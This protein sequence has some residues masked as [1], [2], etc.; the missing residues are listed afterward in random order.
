MRQCTKLAVVFYSSDSG[1]K[2]KVQERFLMRKGSM[3]TKHQILLSQHDLVHVIKGY[4]QQLLNWF[5]SL[6]FTRVIRIIRIIRNI[7]LK[8]Y[9]PYDPYDTVVF[10]AS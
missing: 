9:D 3:M 5:L 4:T 6:V 7:T 8:S 2:V 10:I 1:S